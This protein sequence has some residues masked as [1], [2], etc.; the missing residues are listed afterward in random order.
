MKTVLK[1]IIGSVLLW[2]AHGCYNDKYDELNPTSTLSSCDTVNLSYTHNISRIFA[3]YC[4]SCH[5][6]NTQNGN[7]RL[8][9]YS[10]VYQQVKNG[11]LLGTIEQKPGYNPMPPGTHLESC[12]IRA[13]EKWI[14]LGAPDN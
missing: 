3:S 9:T 13:I 12:N 1:I 4:I 7:A 8:D 11:Q 10:G 5:N 6:A 14:A 2:V